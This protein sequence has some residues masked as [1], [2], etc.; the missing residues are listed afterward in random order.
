M[1]PVKQEIGYILHIFHQFT[2][3]FTHTLI[4]VLIFPGQYI[5]IKGPVHAHNT[6]G[7]SSA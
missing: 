3:S 6:L 4:H 7:A 2:H 5:K 1:T